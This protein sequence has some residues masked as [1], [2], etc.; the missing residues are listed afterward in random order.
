MNSAKKANRLQAYFYPQ[1]M[2]KPLFT[3]AFNPLS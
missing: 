2:E 3:A 1:A